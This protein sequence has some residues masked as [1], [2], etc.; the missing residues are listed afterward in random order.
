LTDLEIRHLKLLLE[1][2]TRA[3]LFA[4]EATEQLEDFVLDCRERGASVRG[5]S[6]ALGFS[7]SMVQTWTANAR[8]RRDGSE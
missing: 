8:R 6:D 3:A 1:L 2:R 4:A 5:M 7:P